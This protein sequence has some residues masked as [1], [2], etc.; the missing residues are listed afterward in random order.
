MRVRPL[1]AAALLAAACTSPSASPPPPSAGLTV[2]G[3]A[4][5]RTALGQLEPAW[6][7]AHPDMPLTVSTGSSAALRTQIE[8]GAPADVFLAADTVNPQRLVEGGFADGDPVPLAV[9][10]LAIVTPIDNPGRVTDIADL[11]RPGLKII[12]AGP[13]VPISG[14]VDELL[15]RPGLPP[16]FAAAYRANVVSREDDVAAVLAKV[17]LGEGDAGIVYY[18]DAVASGTVHTIAM[19]RD[20]AVRATYAGVVVKASRDPVRARAFLD[21]LTGPEA[22][23]ILANLGFDPPAAG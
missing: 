17:Q 5:L 11:A 8:L 19:P 23:R 1:V 16:G 14:Y 7:S 15:R 12:A 9:A 10:D 3:A 4:S 6:E 2:Y 13:S 20:L 22:Q 18:P 21:W